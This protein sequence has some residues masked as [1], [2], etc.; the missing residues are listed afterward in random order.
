MYVQKFI[1]IHLCGIPIIT[2]FRKSSLKVNAAKRLLN[3][4]ENLVMEFV[5]TFWHS[6]S[7]GA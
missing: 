3:V 7:I 6:I 5:E 4:I 1:K 2:N